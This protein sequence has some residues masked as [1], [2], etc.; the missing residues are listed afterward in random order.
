MPRRFYA[1]P[2]AEVAPDLL[3]TLLVRELNGSR[4]IGRIVETEA[5][6]PEDPASHSFPGPN[7]RNRTMFGPPGHAYVYRS[8][9]VH[10]CLNLVADRGSAVLVR[11][12]EP[13]EG[14]EEMARRR[15]R[16]EPHLLCAGPGRLC[17][18]FGLDLEHDGPDVTRGQ[19]FW[20]SR[21][22]PVEEIRISGRIGLTRAR[23]VP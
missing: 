2:A 12:V 16:G 19:E 15:G 6:A 18:A 21:G 13:L 7:A 22:E 10:R 11:A 14:L 4:L 5:Y 17:Q 1:R 8:Y 20:V 23:E 9:G 3:G